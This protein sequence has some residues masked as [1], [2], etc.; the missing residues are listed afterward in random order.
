[1]DIKTKDSLHTFK[2]FDRVQDLAGK[3]R[4]G[5]DKAKQ[6]ISDTI[7]SGDRS[8]SEYAGNRLEAYEGA[9]ARFAVHSVEKT[10]RWGV[11]ETGRNIQK[12]K[13]RKGKPEIKVDGTKANK[14]KAPNQPK[15]LEAPKSAGK[16]A[17]K[18]TK[19]SIK[20]ASK[21]VK[22]S[23]KAVKT[24]V[25]TAEKTVK[26]TEKAAKVAVKAAKAAAKAAKA[27]AQA[28]VKFVKVAV[29]AIIAATKAVV[30]AIKGIAAAIAAGGWVAVVVILVIVVIGGIV[31]AVCSIFTPNDSGG[32]SVAYMNSVCVSEYDR[33]EAEV[34]NNSKYDYLVIE[35]E[36]ASAKDVIAVFA[37][38]TNTESKN[39]SKVDDKLQDEYRTVFNAMNSLEAYST[40][41]E[42]IILKEYTDENGNPYTV[43]ETVEK[44]TLHIVHY[45]RTASQGADYFKF[46][47]QQMEQLDTLLSSDF[48]ELWTALVD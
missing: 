24:S 8:E 48:D 37:V 26:A 23:A 34:I 17:T 28:T 45:S 40:T 33:C 43:E 32:Y 35:G 13:S 9:T 44:V 15:L 42:E 12:L 27:A 25:K 4:E 39:F 7:E 36:E 19:G 3:T 29:K 20:T 10:G 41:S 18:T 31:A 14:L 22:D 30:A 46:T 16:T 2:T 11:R 38:Y 6:G 5:A 21:G 1:M 47:E